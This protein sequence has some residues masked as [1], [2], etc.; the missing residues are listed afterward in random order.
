MMP[1]QD[2]KEQNALDVSHRRSPH[3]FL[4]QGANLV[5]ASDNVE[6]V[7]STERGWSVPETAT[8]NAE[9]T[10]EPINEKVEAKAASCASS[11]ASSV[12]KRPC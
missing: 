7:R 2:R 5:M 10:Q 1:C 11:H 12:I 6:S 9:V 3:D 4:E 8:L